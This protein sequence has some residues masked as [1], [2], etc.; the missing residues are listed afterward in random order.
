MW[1]GHFYLFENSIGIDR[2]TI[3][4][5]KVVKAFEVQTEVVRVEVFEIT[6]VQIGLK[7]IVPFKVAI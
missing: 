4:V 3:N 6:L 5:L 1:S 7:I 2:Y